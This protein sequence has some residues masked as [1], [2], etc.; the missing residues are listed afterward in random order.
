[1]YEFTRDYKVIYSMGAL[2][3]LPPEER[4]KHFATYKG[5]TCVGG[6][7]AHLVFVEKPFIAVAPDWE[8]NEFFYRSG[9]L[10]SYYHDWEIIQC[11]EAIFACDS[12]NIV[13]RHAVSF[14]IAKKPG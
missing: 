9:D 13:H 12:S 4:Q 14:I 3:F 8:K 10:A 2:Q 6:V 7:N 1:G 11:G 5:H